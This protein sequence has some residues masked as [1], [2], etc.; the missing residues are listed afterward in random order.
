MKRAKV[1]V[2]AAATLVSAGA[3]AE[4]SRPEQALEEMTVYATPV[5]S[6]YSVTD[7]FAATKTDT[8]ILE[9]PAS[10]QVVPREVIDDQQALTVMDAVKNV[11]G[12]QQEPGKFY[13]QYL[14]RGFS[15][16]YG[17]SYRNG[18]KLEGTVGAVDMAFVDRV[19]VIKGPAS[20]LYG[21]IEPG[22]F[23]NTVTKRPQAEAAYSF[24]QEAGSWDT[25]RTTM[26]ATG[27]V[28]QAGTVLY[29]LIGVYDKANSWVDYD[30]RDNSA[31]AAYF[32][33][34]PSERF[35]L[36]LDV[37]HYNKSMSSPD[38][39]GQI[40]V[41][42]NRPLDLSKHFSISD[43]VMKSAFP[44]EVNRTLYAFDWNF[45]INDGWKLTQRFQYTKVDETQTGLGNWGFDRVD[46]ITR[47]FIYNPLN[48][49]MY[50]TN[51]DLNGEFNT[52][53]IQHRLLVGLDWYRYTDDWKG[54]V[55]TDPSIPPL[56]VYNP[57]RGGLLPIL[58]PL[59]SQSQSNTLWK[60][61][62]QD[63]GIY[64][65]DQIA[66]TQRWDLLLGGRY[67]WA[68]DSY[69]LTYGSN[70]SAC[71][72]NCTGHPMGH[73]PTDKA[74]SPRAGLLY[75]LNESASLYGSY[76]K[77]FGANNSSLLANGEKADPQ[78]GKQYEL[79]AKANLM[80]GRVMTSATLF[81]LTKNNV[82][83]TNPAD[84]FGPQIPTGEVRSRGLEFDIAGRVTNHVSVIGSYTY[85]Q[86]LITKDTNIPSN[87]GNRY[88][89][90]P[91]NSASMW[92]KY[93]TAPDAAQGWAYG[94]GVY[95]N[96]QRQGDNANTFQLPGYA[97]VD[98]MLTYRTKLGPT[99]VNAQVNV[100]N[101]FDRTYWDGIGWSTAS[102]GSPR[103]VIGSLRVDF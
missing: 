1:L 70:D 68:E 59:V 54:F 73:W 88:P 72:P 42:G 30:F 74:F 2:A 47:G 83:G 94:A 60:T 65:Q 97:T 98:A 79:G 33:L 78:E 28:N 21:R 16:G 19:E 84:P 53:S 103:A 10:V 39:T 9:T 18:L 23:V 99:K 38:S 25:Y 96:G 48:R 13:D 87:Q 5:V 40:P 91:Y 57:V 45:K 77:S 11:S 29:R 62:E 102:Y 101:L 6:E 34:K 15:S 50:S 36:N 92:A 17:V 58:N 7:A 69:S 3:W 95:L 93:D 22:G 8:P 86:V 12:V 20:M 75:K 37:E 64:L 4:E 35:Q 31:F 43:P 66:L 56:N 24:Q 46:T 27:P 51:L 41:S 67:D 55:G 32:T 81:Q 100:K 71:Y 80:G 61:M 14:I 76:S 26:D 90:V 82:L 49:D 44:Y 52:A 89:G 63:Y 85:D